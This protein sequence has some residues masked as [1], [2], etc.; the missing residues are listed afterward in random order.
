M[1]PK[2]ETCQLGPAD[3]VDLYRANAKGRPAVWRCR[4]HV[5]AAP[6]PELTR[7]VETVSNSPPDVLA[8]DGY[9]WCPRTGILERIN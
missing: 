4:E 6:D 9:Q 2:C 8:P 7:I 3:G 1:Q 5:S